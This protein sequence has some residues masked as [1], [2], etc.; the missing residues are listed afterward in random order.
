M[1]QQQR[2][3]AFVLFVLMLMVVAEGVAADKQAGDTAASRVGKLATFLR[4]FDSTVI[5]AEVDSNLQPELAQPKRML[6]RSIQSRRRK[7]NEQDVAQWR[8]ISSRED[9]TRFRDT[10]IARLRK[11]LGTFPVPPEDLKVRVTKTLK[12]DG[13]GF[14]VECLVFQSRPGLLVTANLYRPAESRRKVSGPKMPGI[15]I[16]P[17]HHNPKTQSELQDMGMTWARQGCVVLVMDNLGHGERRQHPFRSSSDFPDSFRASRQD[18]YFRYN[19]GIQL[20]LIG[21][22]LIGWMVWDL[23]RG[24]DLLLE[25]PG[26]DS[27]RI[28]LLG[29]VAG[30]GDPA[31]VTAAIDSRIAAAVPFNFG[32]PQPESVFPLPKDAEL[33][34]NYIGGG[35]W[36]STRNLRDSARGGF[37]PWVIV[38]SIAPRRLI[39]AHEFTW[40]REHDPVWNRLQQIYKWHDVPDRLSSANGYGR[41]TLTSKEASHCNNIGPHH[42]SQIHLAFEK[43]FGIPVPEPEYQKRFESRELLCVDDFE[44]AVDISLTPVHRLADR[45]A[46]QRGDSVREELSGLTPPN[47]REA[48]I[49]R[50][51][52]LLGMSGEMQLSGL[53]PAAEKAGSIRVLKVLRGTDEGIVVPLLVLFPA[54]VPESGAPLVVVVSQAGKAAVLKER[55]KEIAELLD[56]GVAVALPDL[57]GTGESRPDTYRGR[58][59]YATGLSSSTL[60]FGKTLVGQRLRDLL[61]VLGRMKNHS[62]VDKKKIAVWGESLAKANPPDRRTVVPLGIDEEPTLSEPLG[63][64]LALLAGV[65]EPDVKAV[66]ACGGLV[67][68]RSVLDSQFVYLP[69]DF[70]VPG[71]LTAGDL[72]D[73]GSGIAPRPL[74]VE[75]SVTGL[76]QRAKQES[77]EKEWKPA[78]DSYAAEQASKNLELSAGTR[79][80]V[81]WLIDSLRKK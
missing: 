2:V 78:K 70:V 72:C 25:Q 69:H 27:E 67:S 28:I 26:I 30:G 39:Y 47:K 76:N 57:R 18:Y 49:N 19:V 55:S 58:R 61:I 10:R 1:K 62:L 81:R 13:D 33:S 23:M 7:R 68:I 42:R 41:V 40:D 34:F 48:L 12:G 46:R 50:W 73:L 21:D 16:C 59:S 6:S 29:S 32:G 3:T 8:S 5:P 66:L 64:L 31:A 71:A 75:G 20:H 56:A 44:S 24:V 45:L 17:S 38:G 53:E 60:M 22:S 35:S 4:E 77:V 15:L 65:Y 37:L 80:A 79:S 11:S 43:W 74:R 36:E 9:W 63:P 51:S 52:K 14:Q 54:D